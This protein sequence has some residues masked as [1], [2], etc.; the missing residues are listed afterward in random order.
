MV[1]STKWRRNM[2]EK[3]LQKEKIFIC[4]TCYYLI[5]LVTIDILPFTKLGRTHF[6]V[7]PMLILASVSI[8]YFGILAGVRPRNS[9]LIAQPVRGSGTPADKSRHGTLQVKAQER[10]RER[11]AIDAVAGMARPAAMPLTT[12]SCAERLA[13][14]WRIYRIPR[15]GSRQRSSGG[16][17]KIV[18][19]PT[20]RGCSASRL[21]NT[22]SAKNAGA[23]GGRPMVTDRET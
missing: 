22:S 18:H 11:A 2:E 8:S 16:G 14:C 23:Y 21:A 3:F 6:V 17:R 4:I 7:Y 5:H 9:S 10:G 1:I 20:C 12:G 15:T 19:L 13:P